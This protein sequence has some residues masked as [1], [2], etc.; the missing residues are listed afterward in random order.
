[1]AG[2]R[3]KDLAGEFGF[4]WRITAI[5][6]AQFTFRFANITVLFN[7]NYATGLGGGHRANPSVQIGE[8]PVNATS[9]DF[10]PS[11]KGGR[12]IREGAHEQT[13]IEGHRASLRHFLTI[14]FQHRSGRNRRAHAPE[15]LTSG[16]ACAKFSA[17][18]SLIF[19]DAAA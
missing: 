3:S 11:P 6:R 16:Q 13:F 10:L 7:G 18:L 4:P 12:S 8:S 15:R 19:F 5:H 14:Y 2:T 9:I 1:M 17:K